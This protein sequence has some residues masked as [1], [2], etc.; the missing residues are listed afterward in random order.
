MLA[1][2][3]R[4]GVWGDRACREPRRVGD[5]TVDADVDE[6]AAGHELGRL[7]DVGEI[8]DHRR[9]HVRLTQEPLPLGGRPRQ[10]GRMQA[11]TNQVGLCEPFG[12]D[13]VRESVYSGRLAQASSKN[14]PRGQ[15]PGSAT[16]RLHTGR[17]RRSG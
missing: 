10:E 14:G 9:G 5:E 4:S 7:E 8:D 6:A 1:E 17:A 16:G 11:L 12:E 2:P 15:C 13:K 3:R